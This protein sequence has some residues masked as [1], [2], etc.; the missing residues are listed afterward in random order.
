MGSGSEAAEAEA[1]AEAEADADADADD[2]LADAFFLRKNL[3]FLPYEASS[4]S[5][6]SEAAGVS[7]SSKGSGW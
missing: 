6:D 7:F 1:E 4:G 5:T 2:A 3:R